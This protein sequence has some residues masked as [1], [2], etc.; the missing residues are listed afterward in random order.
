M[1]A[2]FARSSNKIENTDQATSSF[3]GSTLRHRG[4][5]EPKYELH[6]LQWPGALPISM[7]LGIVYHSSWYACLLRFDDCVGTSYAYTC[8]HPLI[9]MD[10]STRMRVNSCRLHWD[11]Q[12]NMIIMANVIILKFRS[13]K[14]L[15]CRALRIWWDAILRDTEFH[16]SLAQG[17]TAI[18]L[19]CGSQHQIIEMCIYLTF[20]YWLLF[21]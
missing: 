15:C 10:Q 8:Y 2:R 19:V 9:V 18:G 6:R 3:R 13:F 12:E 11:E 1:A 7:Q 14:L 17:I 20:Y 5:P 16:D 21:C 4:L